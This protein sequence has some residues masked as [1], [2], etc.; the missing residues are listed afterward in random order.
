MTGINEE[1]LTDQ[2]LEGRVRLIEASLRGLPEGACLYQYTRVLSGFD[3]PRQPKYDNPVTEAFVRDRLK[4]LDENAGFRRI[5]LRWCLT[6]EPPKANPF[7]RKPTEQAGENARM[8][9]GFQELGC[10]GRLAFPAL[11]RNVFGTEALNAVIDGMTTDLTTWGY[12]R[13]GNIMG[14]RFAL[15]EAMLASRSL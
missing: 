14:L 9:C 2:E 3:I 8:F 10:L 13:N 11:A 7:Q 5:D 6:I 1:S 15:A 12:S 4:F